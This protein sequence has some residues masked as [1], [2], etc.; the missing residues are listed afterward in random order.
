MANKL[1]LSFQI[2]FLS[3][4][5]TSTVVV[6]LSTGPVGYGAPGAG[7]VLNDSL[8]ATATDVTNL[9]GDWSGATVT[10]ASLILGVLTLNISPV[11]ASGSY[12]NIAGTVLF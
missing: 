3:D 7:N 8:A 9:S 6:N 1:T 5:T 11:P 4:G 12:G 2:G 10:K